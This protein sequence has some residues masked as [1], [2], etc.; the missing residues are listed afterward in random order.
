MTCC[1][2]FSGRV[3]FRVWASPHCKKDK[4]QTS[5]FFDEGFVEAV[6]FAVGGFVEEDN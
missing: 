2:R 1:L 6:W 4:F 5:N 3:L